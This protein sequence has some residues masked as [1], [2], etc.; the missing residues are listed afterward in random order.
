MSLTFKVKDNMRN[1]L[2]FKYHMQNQKVIILFFNPF[3]ILTEFIE[4]YF[5]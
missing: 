4:F 2:A 1:N 3:S 5:T